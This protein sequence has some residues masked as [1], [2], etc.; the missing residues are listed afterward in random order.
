M[1][2]T[3]KPWAEPMPETQFDLMRRI[4]DAPSPVGLEAAMTYGVLEPYFE[5][6]APKSWHLHQFKGHAAV[7][8][9][10]HPGRDELFKVM[11]V[12]HA[13]KIRMQVRSIG[14]DGKVWIN[15]DS[16]LPNV[17]IGHEVKLFSEDPEAPG[18]YRIIQ[19]GTVEALGAIHFSDP[20]QREGRKG[21]KKEQIYLDLQ[22]HGENKKQ[23][24]LNLGVRPGDSI[25][26]DRPIRHGFSPDTFY[27]AYLDN[28]LGCFV[29]AE[30]A[31]LI[32]EAG[33]TEKVRVLFAIA[34]YEEIGRF[35][36]RVLAGQLEPD[37]IIGVDVN[38]DYV[39]A[40]GIGDR[41][42]Q[43]LE[44]GKGFT[45][46]VGAIASEQLNRIIETTAREHGIPMQRDIVG[47]DTGTDG[48]AGVLA[49]ID[50][51]ATSIGF[52][53][54]NMHTIS[55]TGNTQDVLA[56]IHVLTRTLQALDAL[57]DPHREFLDNHPRLDQA[58]PLTHQGSAKPEEHQAAPARKATSHQQKHPS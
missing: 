27:G 28:G 26:F 5:S 54:R 31:R 37:V 39:A 47:A 10:T 13:D 40:P 58:Q 53:I 50:C 11:I 18:R 42:M 30:V 38:H 36:S 32:A 41:R 8:W 46:S 3:E 43:P 51:A 49:A 57:P 4:L 17:L 23:Q 56:A 44:M 19:G 12:G 22:I 29:T 21:I 35:G 6:F 55:E 20:A 24:V 9:D 33:G 2:D 16:F 7:V 14:D 34:S 48:M 45:M 25:I 1:S 15:T 52:P